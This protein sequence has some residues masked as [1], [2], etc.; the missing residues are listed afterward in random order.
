[1]STE[2]PQSPPPRLEPTKLSW[3]ALLGRWVDFARSSLAL[4]L[5]DSDTGRV[6]RVVPD[7]IGLQAV[8][9]ALQHLSDLDAEER[10]LGLDRAAVLI[11]RHEAALAAAWGRRDAVPAAVDELVREAR[12]QLEAARRAGG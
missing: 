5:D 12:G 6:R 1:M 7:L 4:P 8:W 2:N 10:A 3:A 11:D 9:F